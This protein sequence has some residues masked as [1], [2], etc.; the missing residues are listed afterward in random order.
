MKKGHDKSFVHGLSSFERYGSTSA[1]ELIGLLIS[2]LK[3][4]Q[5][6]F[7]R[8]DFHRLRLQEIYK[9]SPFLW[10]CY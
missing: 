10:V 2:S 1:L 7:S 3:S 8:R 9:Q 5:C 6:E 4:R